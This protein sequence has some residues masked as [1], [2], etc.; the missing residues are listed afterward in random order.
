MGFK[1]GAKITNQ[2][3]SLNIDIINQPVTSSL[4]QE[5]INLNFPLSHAKSGFDHGKT[6][7]SPIFTN[8]LIIN[9]YLLAGIVIHSSNIV[10]FQ[11]LFEYFSK[12]GPLLITE[13]PPARPH[14]SHRDFFKVE[15][16]F[17]CG[18][19]QTVTTFAIC[20]DG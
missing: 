1:L 10:A 19:Q 9:Q 16:I 2:T 7:T 15:K 17:C 8:L 6:V 13:L 5:V 12:T 3:D 20:W 11:K 18:H 4:Q 14:D